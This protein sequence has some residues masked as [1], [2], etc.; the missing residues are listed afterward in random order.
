MSWT[1]SKKEKLLYFKQMGAWFVKDTCVGITT[2]STLMTMQHGSL[3]TSC[4]AAQPLISCH[5]HNL[6]SVIECN[7]TEKV[8]MPEERSFW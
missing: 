7:G 5:Y 1:I 2:N 4:C 6:P 8:L 3:T